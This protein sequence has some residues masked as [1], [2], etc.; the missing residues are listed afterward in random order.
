MRLQRKF[1][2][3]GKRKSF[4]SAACPTPKG[5]GA[6][7]FKLARTS[8]DFVGGAKVATTLTDSC[9]VRH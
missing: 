4:L 9:K 8:F 1:S 3:K 7:S 5:V 2:V 6:A